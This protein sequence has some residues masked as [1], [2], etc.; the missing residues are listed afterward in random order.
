MHLLYMV[1]IPY[2]ENVPVEE[3]QEIIE[4][5]DTDQKDVEG[6]TQKYMYLKPASAT[7]NSISLSWKKIKGADGYIV[8]I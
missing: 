6:S 8:V 2:A 5:E 3:K 7:K 1:E 4:N